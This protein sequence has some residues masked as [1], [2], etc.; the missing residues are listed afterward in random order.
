MVE[1]FAFRSTGESVNQG[2]STSDKYCHMIK[3]MYG[4]ELCLHIVQLEDAWEKW[5]QLLTE[6]NKHN[7]MDLV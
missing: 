4:L 3:Y 6:V 7:S 1:A 2:Q 5:A